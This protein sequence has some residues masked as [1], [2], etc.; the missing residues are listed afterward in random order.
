M[1]S[2]FRMA[3]AAT[4]LAATA[5][6]PAAAQDV[7]S[8]PTGYFA[9]PTGYQAGDILVHLSVLGVIPMNYASG[10]GGALAGS[11]VNVS[12]GVSPELD[13]SYFFTQNISVQLIAATTRH[14][15]W[16]TGPQ[17]TVK[18]GST[19]VLP[20]TVT[21]QYH[22]PQ[23]GPI[24][25]YVGVGLTVAFFYDPQASSYLKENNLKMGGLSTGVGPSLNVGFDVPI[26]GN[27]SANVDFKQMFFV[28]GTHV[29]GSA[30][31]ALTNLDPIAVGVGVGYKF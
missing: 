7:F 24:R 5:I 21:A 19:W 27:W 17:G 18:V 13:A 30:V 4:L 14:N 20:P 26:Q 6:T 23:L 15:I 22:F 28:T 16:T 11:K 31:G 25:P 9:E 1:K 29:G 3:A 8:N 10:V 2:M 12:A